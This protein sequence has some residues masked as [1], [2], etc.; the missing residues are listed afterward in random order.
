[1]TKYFASSSFRVRLR[2]LG[3]QGRKRRRKEQE[4]KGSFLI[5]SSSLEEFLVL[6]YKIVRRICIEL[7]VCAAVAD[8]Y[9]PCLKRD[10]RRRPISLV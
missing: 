4:K 5:L 2:L 6:P 3:H 1:M 8:F 9:T 7:C 10:E